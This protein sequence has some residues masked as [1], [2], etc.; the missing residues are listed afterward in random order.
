MALTQVTGSTGIKKPVDFADNEKARFGTGADLEIHHD[1]TNSFIRNQTGDLT[2]RN[3]ADDKD[4]VLETDNGSGGTTPYVICDGSTGLTLLYAGGAEKLQIR[5]AG[6]LISGECMCSSLDVNGAADISGN[7]DFHG[8]VTLDDGDRLR[9]G[10]AN[11]LQVYHDGTHSRITNSQGDLFIQSSNVV[12]ITNSTA[13]ET[14]AKFFMDG[15]CQFY[16]D[17]NQVFTTMSGGVNIIGELEC[18]N[19][20]VDG[21]VDIDVNSVNEQ[22]TIDTFVLNGGNN[23]VAIKCHANQGG[24]PYIFFDAGGTNFVI[25]E[26]WNGT[27]TNILRLG[28]GNNM[29]TVAGMFI[30]ADGHCKPDANNARDLG[31]SSNR[32]RN[33]YTN[34]LNLSNE[35]ST[36]DVDGTWGNYTIQEGEDDLFLINRRNGKKY[37]FN[38]T[39]VN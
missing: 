17:N 36:N 28:A 24:D 2:I 7:V 35:G 12:R 26:Q 18:D 37:K 4:I 38:L 19:L 20:D 14:A 32:W 39:E 33:I 23:K 5:S 13:S 10:D 9:L 27:N 16:H 31:G 25:G 22:T 29:A 11:D 8:N 21:T 34:D 1:S 30:T 15:A 6:V 3:L